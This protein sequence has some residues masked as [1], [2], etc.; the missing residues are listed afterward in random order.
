MVVRAQKIIRTRVRATS[1]DRT[2]SRGA[3]YSVLGRL[4]GGPAQL[5]EFQAIMAQL[6][7]DEQQELSFDQISEGLECLGGWRG[8][9]RPPARGLGAHPGSPWRSACGV[10]G[11][12]RCVY[13]APAHARLAG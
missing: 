11:A 8:G 13:R 10:P 12:A 5:A 7:Y 3:L 6:R 4:M 1:Q 2:V 9:A